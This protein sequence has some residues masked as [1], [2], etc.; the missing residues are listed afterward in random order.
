M[1][2]I[3]KPAG[4]AILTLSLATLGLLAA[5]GVRT[6][7]GPVAA[8]P[9]A[10]PTAVPPTAPLPAG[11]ALLPPDLADW[12][13]VGMAESTRR[14]EIVTDE[15]APFPEKKF[16]RC[17]VLRVRPGEHWSQQ[18]MYTRAHPTPVP[19]GRNCTVRFWGRSRKSSTMFVAIQQGVEPFQKDL[20]KRLTLTPE[21]RLYE[22]PFR[23]THD[24]RKDGLQFVFQV[25]ISP[26]EFD[27]AEP[28]VYVAE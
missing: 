1:R 27:L 10:A 19:P 4:L 21:W 11:K 2:V 7:A 13:V 18:V 5:R 20:D 26:G 9:A 15:S 25:G 14:K 12:N 6:A 22:M 28:Q 8:A 24:Y 23:T 16:V 17:T 3:I